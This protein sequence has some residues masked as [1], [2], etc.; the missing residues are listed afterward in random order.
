MRKIFGNLFLGAAVFLAAVNLHAEEVELQKLL[1][2]EEPSLWHMEAEDVFTLFPQRSLFY[3]NDSAKTALLFSFRNKQHQMTFAG[4]KVYNVSLLFK[5]SD[6]ARIYISFYNR[7]DAGELDNKAFNEMLNNVEQAVMKIAAGKT[8]SQSTI[9]LS[10][11]KKIY[12]KNYFC[13]DY[14]L[15]MEWSYTE[16]T[17]AY[18]AEFITLTIL[19]PDQNESVKINTALTT[20][21]LK[22]RV[23]ANDD[24]D[25]F[26][27]VP[28]TT[29]T[30]RGQGI[31]A[32]AERVMRYYGA[33]SVNQ[34]ILLELANSN[35]GSNLE[36]MRKAI[37]QTTDLLK[38]K[39]N[40]LYINQDLKKKASLIKLVELYNTE[41][42]RG[43]ADKI[44]LTKFTK[45]GN[46]KSYDTRAILLAMTPEL[47]K[48]ARSREI[49]GFTKFKRDVIT[50]IDSGVPLVW[51]RL[52]SIFPIPDKPRRGIGYHVQLITGYNV[53]EN[54]VIYSDSWGPRNEKKKMSWEEAWSISLDIST[55]T[56][57]LDWKPS[58]DNL[59]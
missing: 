14:L 34:N 15:R 50:N 9:P 33:T 58:G 56:P 19:P 4:F 6:L 7:S 28:A 38:I 32:T 48:V 17:T 11:A 55:Y 29:Q 27:E 3:W 2:A 49:I 35:Q 8:G 42:A 41:A 39:Y 45:S 21:D 36:K 23:K 43:N 10:A 46:G 25:R 37:R 12:V 13:D 30:A 47:Y 44:D 31:A 40:S 51:A 59:S 20:F 53:K 24:G 52:T 16:N 54:A 22:R 18:H 1:Q 26:L 5:D 57:M